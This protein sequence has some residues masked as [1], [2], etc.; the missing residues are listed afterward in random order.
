M[1]ALQVAVLQVLLLRSQQQEPVR[2]DAGSAKNYH[3]QNEREDF[4]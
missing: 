4:E 1:S 3:T 2:F